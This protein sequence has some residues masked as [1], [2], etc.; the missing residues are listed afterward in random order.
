M[1]DKKKF[2]EDIGKELRNIRK[3]LGYS[4]RKVLNELIQFY[5]GITIISDEHYSAVERGKRGI[6]AYK[7]LLII[8]YFNEAIDII[9]LN[10]DKNLEKITIEQFLELVKE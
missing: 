5:D 1:K 8:D 4:R 6:S 3:S 2:D 9:K 10:N 7:L